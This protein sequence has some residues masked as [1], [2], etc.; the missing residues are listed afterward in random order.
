MEELRGLKL[1]AFSGIARPQ[2]F[3]RTLAELGVR[4]AGFAEFPDHHWYDPS[5]VGALAR[6]ARGC[7]AQA[8]ITTEKDA[9]RC[10]GGSFSQF[11]LWAL[12]VRLV[13]TGG[14][15]VWE[16]AFLRV[17]RHEPDQRSLLDRGPD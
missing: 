5:E 4:I 1:Y 9:V 7:G 2:N 12:A 6:E 3:A 14:R 8:L 15:S 16:T 17:L 10:V 11:P 13:L